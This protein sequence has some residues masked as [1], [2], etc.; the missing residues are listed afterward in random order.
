M[1][2]FPLSLRQ[3]LY[4]HQQS[5]LANLK[6]EDDPAMALHLT[7]VLLFQQQTGCII[8]VPGKLVPL[9]I[10]FLEPHVDPDRYSVVTRVQQLVAVKW[11]ALASSKS[12]SLDKSPSQDNAHTEAAAEGTHITEPLECT[13]SSSMSVVHT[14]QEVKTLID[15]LKGLVIKPRKTAADNN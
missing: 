12:P 1:Y 8:H 15:E 10:K 2:L 9:V 13:E 5:L 6:E 14:D 7:A 11:K 4:S 3:Q